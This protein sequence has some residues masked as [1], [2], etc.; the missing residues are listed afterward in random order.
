VTHVTH[1]KML[2]TRRRRQRADKVAAG[3]TKRAK[4]FARKNAKKATAAAKAA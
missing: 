3:M 4:K 1:S 2:E